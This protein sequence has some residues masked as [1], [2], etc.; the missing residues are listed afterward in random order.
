MEEFCLQNNVKRI[1]KT[2]KEIYISDARK[3]PSEKL[4]KVLRFKVK[5]R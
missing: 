3:N 1:E 2:H 4:K 5:E